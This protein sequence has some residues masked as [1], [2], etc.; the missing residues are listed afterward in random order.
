M[1][2]R[3]F[4]PEKEFSEY[5]RCVR[6]VHMKPTQ[7]V[8][9]FSKYYVPKPEMVLHAILKGVQK[10]CMTTTPAEEFEFSCFLSG[11]QTNP[12]ILKNKGEL[13]N[14][15]IVFN[16]TAFF[17]ITGIPS[18]EM[19]NKFLDAPS[20]FGDKIFSYHEQLQHAGSYDE[21]IRG[22]EKF[23]ES[24]L[25][26]V[27]TKKARIDHLFYLD[28]NS[29]NLCFI[30]KLAKEAFLSNKQFERI[31]YEQVGINPK[32]Y[33]KIVRFFKAYNIKNA[34]P[35]WDWL[36]IA[37]ECNYHDYQHLSKDYLQFTGFTP[38]QFH[39][40]IESVSPER[41]LGIANEI[42]QQRFC[43]KMENQ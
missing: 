29:D 24:I 36:R 31:F 40:Q 27:I 19:A 11:Q 18:S 8:S 14:V 33:F 13:L 26:N 5:V 12:F 37:A 10:I 32:M 7:D 22:V 15:Q 9:D 25:K 43:Q 41:Q 30:K 38:T 42:Y 34:R 3:D 39:R 4:L 35:D 21:M 20:I 23:M 1:L 6:I 17:K 28:A 2:I 16:P